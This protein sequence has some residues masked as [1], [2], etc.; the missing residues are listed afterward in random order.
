MNF[1]NILNAIEKAD[2]EIYDRVD[3][4]RKAM[5][6]FK[7]IG[8][9][10]ALTAI[11]LALGSM[12]NKAYSQTPPPDIVD[13]LNFA[14]T[15]EYL[16]SEFYTTA[17]GKT[18]FIDAAE[19]ASFTL[20]Q[21]QEAAHVNFLTTTITSLSGTPITK[22]EFDFTGKG[23]FPD[24]FSN[25][26]VFLSLAQ[27]F[28]DIGVRAY[29]GQITGLMPNKDVLTAA[30]QIHSVEGRHAAHVRYIRRA[31]GTSPGEKP[32]ITSNDA[33]DVG[34][35]VENTYAGED[36]VVQLGITLTTLKFIG[37][38]IATEAFD[39]PL[40]MDEVNAVIGQFIV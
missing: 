7:N 29:K 36:N 27:A 1:Q 21:Q 22:P 10:L 20:I 38:R 35:P 6:R 14:L 13:I 33:D 26:Q 30:L 32:W 3:S 28:E 31:N 18:G 19:T 2:P 39:E 9:K 15:L 17:L 12:L 23:A 40:S 8:G 4:R 34:K 11:P 5:R 25:Y 16:E 24:I 37:D